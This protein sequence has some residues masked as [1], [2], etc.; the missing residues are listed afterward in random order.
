VI[1][2]K[3]EAG[4]LYRRTQ[5]EMA[6]DL[7]RLILHSLTR[8][9]KPPARRRVLDSVS[10]SIQRGEKVGIIGE[11]GSG[12]STLLKVVSG[13]LTLTAGSVSVHGRIAPLI[14]LGAGFD[15]DLSLKENIIY[16]GVL[17][18]FSKAQMLERVTRILDFAELTERANE[19]LKALSSGMNARLAFA[20][21]TD[22]HPDILLLDEVLSV[23]DQN[24][25][26]KSAERLRALWGEHSTIVLVSHDLGFVQS[27]CSR[28]LWLRQGH[29]VADGDPAE[30]IP[31]YQQS[32]AAPR[33]PEPATV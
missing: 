26:S 3:V 29:L 24:F 14:E 25:R 1:A 32:A 30:I 13:I 27:Q 2:I 7:K 6:Y 18:G 28:T 33:L 11:N 22:E 21:A 16:Y 10:F 4:T 23:G 5:E 31:Q 19:P 12:K 9:Y 17:L 20:V 8:K 15:P